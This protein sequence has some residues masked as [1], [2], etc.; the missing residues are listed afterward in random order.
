MVQERTTNQL[1]SIA[2]TM[3]LLI[4]RV[5]WQ[6]PRGSELHIELDVLLNIVLTNSPNPSQMT[7]EQ[8]VREAH[9]CIGRVM[10]AIESKGLVASRSSLW[11]SVHLMRAE[12]TESFRLILNAFVHEWCRIHRTGIDTSAELVAPPEYSP[13]H[14]ANLYRAH[15]QL[16][17]Q[18]GA[19]Q[20]DFAGLWRGSVPDTRRLYI[21]APDAAC[22]REMQ[23]NPDNHTVLL[24]DC[25][26]ICGQGLLEYIDRS[27]GLNG[28]PVAERD[29]HRTGA[30][31]LQAALMLGLQ[32]PRQLPRTAPLEMYVNGL[33]LGAKPGEL[34]LARQLSKLEMYQEIGEQ[35]RD[36]EN[37]YVNYR[38]LSETLGLEGAALS[39]ELGRLHRSWCN[40]RDR[41]V[42]GHPAELNVADLRAIMS[43]LP[44]KYRHL[45][46]CSAEQAWR[47]S[48]GAMVPELEL[49]ER[50]RMRAAAGDVMSA[51]DRLMHLDPQYRMLFGNDG[52]DCY[53]ALESTPSTPID[54]M[55]RS[56][57]FGMRA[58]VWNFDNCSRSTH[59][60]YIYGYNGHVSPGA[61][62]NYAANARGR[63]PQFTETL[64]RPR[65]VHS[66]ITPHR[67][68][69]VGRALARGATYLPNGS[70][71]STLLP[72]RPGAV[73]LMQLLPR[74]ARRILA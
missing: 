4:D 35:M 44:E 1:N 61:F 63:S 6:V 11:S 40:A 45:S 9:L 20:I 66:V 74:V 73:S 29:A 62:S 3:D 34:N 60:G 36:M 33:D 57:M 27:I 53:S 14:S 72:M 56:E 55:R 28:L 58:A 54:S 43:L 26:L 47:Q 18:L 15:R 21:G 16:A 46:T 67:A 25:S 71:I 59:G 51:V 41:L 65:T 12:R 7:V 31:R 13:L 8:L 2:I 49:V 50:H 23:L 38:H 22:L 32:E 39:S 17:A 52:G 48:R 42:R 5:L 70:Q 10:Q 64:V 69:D 68:R 30:L 24:P 19:R 37:R